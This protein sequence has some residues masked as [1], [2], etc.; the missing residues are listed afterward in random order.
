[1]KD[2]LV[3]GTRG[4]TLARKQTQMVIDLLRAAYPKLKVDT[5]IITTTG[6]HIQDTPLAKIGGKGVFTKELEN[7]LLNRD[8]DFAVHSLKD[9]PVEL[10]QGLTIGAYL[11]RETPNDVL[12]SKGNLTLYDIPRHGTIATGSLRRKLQLLR[13]RDDLQIVDVRGNIETRIKKLYDNNWDGLILAYAALH[14]LEKTGLIS[15]IIPAE[16]MHPAVGQGIIAIE[17]RDEN[18]MHTLFSAINHAETETCAMAE[19][20]FLAGLGGGCQVPVGVTSQIGNGQL[21]LSGIY[22]P[23][24]DDYRHETL[25]MAATEPE[26]AGQQL[27]A[28]ILTD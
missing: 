28:Q 11:E 14:R 17:C 9:L 7:S 1:M 20:A 2:Q 4:S 19:R 26:Q 16:I 24:E 21:R 18:E 22:I 6:D 27:A 13:Y 8:I 10:P 12:I 3:A 23:D 5:R 25:T 15:E